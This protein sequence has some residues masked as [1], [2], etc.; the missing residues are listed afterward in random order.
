MAKKEEV[1]TDEVKDKPVEVAPMGVA[2]GVVP[3]TWNE[4]ALVSI[5]P[6]GY[7]EL[8]FETVT[9]TIDLD[10]GEKPVEWIP[11]LKGGRLTKFMPKEDTTITLEL[12]PIYSGNGAWPASGSTATGEGLYDL[13]DT[14]PAT[15]TDPF[16]ALVETTTRTKIRCT[17]LWTDNS[18]IDNATALIPTTSTAD[19]ASYAEGYLTKIKREYTDGIR[20][21]TVTMKFPASD[22]DG[23][24]CQI[25]QSVKNDI[26]LAALNAYTGTTKF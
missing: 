15:S 25:V 2:T 10:E 12:Y 18:S 14:L 16:Q 1:R 22:K 5:S 9:E 13:L 11:T 6:V 4:T 20:K 23:D 3:D 7:G 24:S 21:A 19:R 26:P 8:L 17:V